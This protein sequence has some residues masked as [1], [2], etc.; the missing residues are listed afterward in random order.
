MNRKL[1]DT[2]IP[3]KKVIIELVEQDGDVCEFDI[4][5]E[6]IKMALNCYLYIVDGILILNSVD[7]NG[8][9]QSYFDKGIFKVIDEVCKEFCRVYNTQEIILIGAKRTIGRTK[10]RFLKPYHLKVTD[11]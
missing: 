11:L 7:V 5:Y 10:G 4:G 2:N 1:Q 6:G 8:P 3:R 9:G